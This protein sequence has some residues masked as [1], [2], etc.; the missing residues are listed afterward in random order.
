MLIGSFLRSL[1][2]L[3]I[4]SIYLSQVS[5]TFG[6]CVY[7]NG[8]YSAL[9]YI[10]LSDPINGVPF[11][12]LPCGSLGSIG[13]NIPLSCYNYSAC[14]DHT[15]LSFFYPNHIQYSYLNQNPTS[16]IQM[17]LPS[18]KSSISVTLN[19]WCSSNES[20]PK[21]PTL[22][23]WVE[24]GVTNFWVVAGDAVACYNPVTGKNR[25]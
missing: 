4:F 2:L 15:L 24:S 16:G 1:Y 9:S 10:E 12:V 21:I 5:S 3:L 17:V 22:N 14:E 8:D 6:P 11:Y 19:I 13:S 20:A 7:N 18:T 23:T 25:Y